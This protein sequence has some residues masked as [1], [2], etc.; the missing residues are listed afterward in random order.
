M[1]GIVM[2]KA[3]VV[4]HGTIRGPAHELRD[5]FRNSYDET[6]FIHHPLLFIKQNRILSSCLEKY[7]KEKLVFER[8]A[9]HWQGPE[10]LLYIKD[11]LY[12]LIWVIKYGRKTDLLVGS[13][14]LNAFAGLIL[15]RLGIVKKVVYYCIDYVP[16]RFKNKTLNNLYHWVDRVCAEKCDSTWNLSLR[17]IEGRQEKWKQKF[18]HQQVVPHGSYTDQYTK[19]LIS[20]NNFH[21]FEIVYMGTLLKKQG[22][23]LVIKAFNRI[24]KKFPKARFLIIGSGEYKNN[25]EILTKKLGLEKHVIFTGYLDDNET[26]EKIAKAHIAVAP[27]NKKEDIFTYYAD[28]GKVKYYLS[29]G[30]PLIITDVPSVAKDIAKEKCGLVI[31]YDEKELTKA[32]EKYFSD[33]KFSIDYRRNALKYSEKFSWDKLYRK[34]LKEI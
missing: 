27:Y 28:P 16:N 25:L 18:F 34:A 11:L 15:K 19:S 22:V 1:E 29:L 30:I 7:E 6:V 17:M 3:I 20:L 10:S 26:K 21:K 23:Q 5:Y 32:I 33:F 8:R 4:T 13:G 24:I 2:R 12:T 14:N 31:N 9:F